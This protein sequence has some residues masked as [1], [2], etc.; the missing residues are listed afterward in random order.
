[1]PSNDFSSETPML[2]LSRGWLWRMRFAGDERQTVHV[3]QWNPQEKTV[4]EGI[5]IQIDDLPWV[6]R[7]LRGSYTADE[8]P[9]QRQFPGG[10][11]LSMEPVPKP[12]L[13]IEQKSSRESLGESYPRSSVRRLMLFEEDLRPLVAWLEERTKAL[14][15][16]MRG[17]QGT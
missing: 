12:E 14:G 1:M 5:E 6:A 13:W 4:G 15:V 17:R 11:V 16:G 8:W 10:S 2:A 7:W 9:S 3:E